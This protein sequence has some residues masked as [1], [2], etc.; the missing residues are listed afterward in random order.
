MKKKMISILLSAVAAFGIWLYVVMVVNP[1]WEQTYADIPVVFQNENLLAERGLMIVSD[2]KPTVRLRLSGNRSDLMELNSANISVVCNLA[3]IEASG[4]FSLGYTVYYANNAIT[5][6]EK[7]PES[8]NLKVEKRVTKPVS[9]VVIPQGETPQGYIDDRENLTLDYTSIEITG[10]QSVIDR[11]H[12]AR[13]YVDMEGKTQTIVGQFPY[14]LVDENGEAVDTRQVEADIEQVSLVLKILRLKDITIQVE[15]LY[16]GGATP[17]NS[18]VVWNPQTILVAGSETT[19][20]GMSDVLVV[21]SV[22]LSKPL[23]AQQLVFDIELPKD[24]ENITGIHQ[25]DVTVEIQALESKTLQI[26]NIR[27][28]NVPE[29]M[30]AV[31]RNQAMSIT[32]RGPAAAIAKLT[33]EDVVVEVD[34]SNFQGD[35]EVSLT[36][37]IIVSAYPEIGAFGSYSVVAMLRADEAA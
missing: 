18:T 31:I 27:P 6:A 36:P 30:E 32:F 17:G 19:L 4:E 11:V 7:S 12:E 35:S 8:I 1:E 34:F 10:P 2:S 22:D 29:G 9:V 13:V 23:E 25:V 20:A 24:V 21:G 5:V 26:T 28:V 15:V 16:G 14:V 33:A 3:S 37:N